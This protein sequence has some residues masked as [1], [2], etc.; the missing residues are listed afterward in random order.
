[1][2]RLVEAGPFKMAWARTDEPLLWLRGFA[3]EVIEPDA[4][5][6]YDCRLRPDEHI[7]IQL[8]L[9]GE[10]FYE[11]GGKV[12]RLGVGSAFFDRIPGDF[13]YGFPGGATQ[14]Y[15]HVWIDMVGVAAESLWQHA[16]QVTGGPLLHLGPDNPVAPLM[17]SFV[18]EHATGLLSDR[19]QASAR[20]YELVML[21][22]ST[23]TNRRTT[24]SPLVQRALRAIHERGLRS[25]TDVGTIAEAA[26]CS[27]EHLARAFAAATGLSPHDYLLQHRLRRAQHELRTTADAL[28]AI[29]RRCGFSGANYFVRAF[30]QRLGITPA[31]FRSRPWVVRVGE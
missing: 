24:T 26:G 12:T 14:P 25:S 31:A 17:L 2:A 28:E 27:R 8:T 1:M 3:H 15:E 18:N 6:F 20:L 9:S 19:Y 21:L 22:C 5:Y 7:G 16:M 29:A 4:G 10:G 30:R 13:R 23:V 11:R